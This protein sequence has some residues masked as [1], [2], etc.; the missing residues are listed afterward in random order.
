MPVAGV[1][2]GEAIAGGWRV[3]AEEEEEEEDGEVVEERRDWGSC[4][5]AEEFLGAPTMN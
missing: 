2:G 4:Q 5:T 3:G 1:A